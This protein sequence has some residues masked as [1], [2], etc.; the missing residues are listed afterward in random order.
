MR[1][2]FRS[3]S[4]AVVLGLLLAAAASAA[5]A[6]PVYQWKDANGVTHYSDKPPAGEQY[7]DRRIDPRGEPVAQAEPAG[8]S[9]QSP[10]CLQARKN[11]D[12]LNTSSRV[13]QAGA[14]GK[15]AGQPL[16]AQQLANQRTLAEAA[17]KAYCT[18]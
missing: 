10:E 5:H 8:K 18:P 7:K 11:L 2:T 15:P 3:L 17:Q 9:V 4:S 14:D 1:A 6:A 12:V 13:L 16:D